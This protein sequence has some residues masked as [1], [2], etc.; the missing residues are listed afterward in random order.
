M[1]KRLITASMLMVVAGC[2]VQANDGSDDLGEN[3]AAV[4][5]GTTYVMKLPLM[6]GDTG[7]C[8]DVTGA[9]TTA[10]ANI[11]EW[12]CSGSAAQKF[13]AVDISGWGSGYSGYFE[14]KNPNSGMCVEIYGAT[15][16]NGSNIDQWGCK[17]SSLSNRDNQAWKFESVNGYYRI[18]SKLASG[19]GVTRCIDIT[20]GSTFTANGTNVE[21]WGCG[22]GGNQTWNPVS[23]SS[24]GTSGIAGVITQSQFDSWFSSKASLYTYSGFTSMNN[25]Y[26]DI[27]NESDMTLRKREVA[28]MLANFA[29]ETGDF[30][31]TEEINPTCGCDSSSC[32]GCPAGSCNY[33][34]R[35]WTQLTWNCNYNS[36]GNA[37]GYD[38][39]HNP[40]WVSSN[41]SISAQTAA[42]YW[43]T[44]KGPGGYGN[45]SHDA[46]AASG[47]SGGFGA[48]IA[49]LNGALE[50][51]SLGG[52]NTAQRDDRINRYKTYCDR[53]GVTYGNN[54]SC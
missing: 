44:Q 26:S 32:G 38:L 47:G 35:G 4:S 36:A 37:L 21:L 27:A 42:W 46:M 28:A 52:S 43:K 5:G 2:T 25:K 40:G 54:L 48:T 8:M 6:S 20:G 45:N 34:G 53:L 1:A 7:N 9:S 41:A 31:Y 14:L 29:H 11:E 16:A 24:G 15:T 49:H 23:T 50:C 13:T 17:S 3:A 33:Y 22:T 10:G 51:P 12:D 30:V 39:L 19:D 18:R